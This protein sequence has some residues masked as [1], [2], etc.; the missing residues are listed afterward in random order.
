MFSN[1][2]L[3]RFAARPHGGMC[4]EAA[5]SPFFSRSAFRPPLEP[6]S[7][8]CGRSQ[9]SADAWASVSSRLV[10]FYCRVVRPL[11]ASSIR[12]SDRRS[13]PAATDPVSA[14]SRAGEAPRHVAASP[15]LLRVTR[16]R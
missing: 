15:V 16:H 9:S 6:R 2:G 10:Y 12:T 1:V 5:C 13:P 7:R 3:V 11:R 8:S 14:P 4:F